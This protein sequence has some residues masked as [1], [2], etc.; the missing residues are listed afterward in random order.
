MRKRNK[1]GKDHVGLRVE[2]SE[3]EVLECQ[4]KELMAS[5]PG[6]E[7]RWHR[8]SCRSCPNMRQVPSRWRGRGAASECSIPCKPRPP[9]GE[10]AAEEKGKELLSHLGWCHWMHFLSDQQA[11]KCILFGFTDVLLHVC[12]MSKKGQKR[13]LQMVVCRHMSAENPTLVL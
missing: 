3:G 5:S 6:M 11:L 8:P 7:K 12:L 13:A 2:A 4:A 10:A 1:H 9:T